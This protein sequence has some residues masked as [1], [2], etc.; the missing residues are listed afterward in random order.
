MTSPGE[1]V[2]IPTKWF[3]CLFLRTAG[4]NRSPITNLQ[5]DSRK[6]MLTWN[7]IRNV[8][9]Q[10]CM[11]STP[12][13]SPTMPS[14]STTQAPKVSAHGSCLMA[15][16]LG[17]LEFSCEMTLESPA[18]SWFPL[19]LLLSGKENVCSILLGSVI[20]TCKLKWPMPDFSGKK[21]YRFVLSSTFYIHEESQKQRKHPKKWS[22]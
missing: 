2:L 22:D 4:D 16:L 19:L 9:Q 5:L 18:C 14:F 3:V 15:L 7:Y 13:N 21:T 8:S 10:E 1:G 20:G 11:I 6:R 17:N 12:P